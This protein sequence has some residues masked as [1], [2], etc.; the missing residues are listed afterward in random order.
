MLVLKILVVDDDSYI[1]ELV[2]LLVAQIG[3][4]EVILAQSGID[5]LNVIGSEP[6]PFDCF[7]FDIQM[8]SMDGIELCQRVRQLQG[9]RHTPIIMLTAMTEKSFIDRA[10][11][12]GATD[13]ATKPFDMIELRARLNMAERLVKMGKETA[14]LEATELANTAL[15]EDPDPEPLHIAG[16]DTI[17]GVTALGN[18]LTALS[19]SGQ[20]ST[21]VFA[22]KADGFVNIE[23][24]STIEERTYFIAEIVRAIHTVLQPYGYLM[25][26]FTPG[27]FICSSNCALP[28]DPETV[29]SEIQS[30]LDDS[31]C[32]FDTGAPMEVDIAMGSPIQPGLVGTLGIDAFFDRVVSRAKARAVAKS[33][34]TRQPNIRT[35]PT[36]L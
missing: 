24:R 20:L 18:Y 35:V 8:P 10:F 29:E 3:A 5:A 34:L 14:A 15:A 16:L 28:L 7:L 33:S 22:I 12:A 13:Y 9:Y 31:N 4:H 19:V 2:P 36:P 26:Q 17:I 32:V 6:V 21:Q 23:A 27:V 30:L 11:L 25:A 1:L